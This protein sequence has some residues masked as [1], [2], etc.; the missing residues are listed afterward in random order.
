LKVGHKL[1]GV[2]I[3]WTDGRYIDGNVI[4]FFVSSLFGAT[5][6]VGFQRYIPFLRNNVENKVLLVSAYRPLRAEQ[7]T[8]RASLIMDRIGECAVTEQSLDLSYLVF[9]KTPAWKLQAGLV[10]YWAASEFRL[11][12]YFKV[13]GK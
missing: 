2:F 1:Y 5:E 13:S 10:C 12:V 3:V 7:M 8:A 9:S 6:C 11:K 4:Q